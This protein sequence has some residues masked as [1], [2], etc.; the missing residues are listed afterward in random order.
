MLTDLTAG[1]A[2]SVTTTV[3]LGEESTVMVVTPASVWQLTPVTG[4]RSVLL[5]LT[6]PVPGA[7]AGPPSRAGGA[8]AGGGGRRG[9]FGGGGGGRGGL[10]CRCGRCA[11]G[12]AGLVRG[13]ASGQ[14]H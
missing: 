8:G 6:W 5:R 10:G 1:L 11:G 3:V 4:P 9:A 2:S 7:A 12:T 13:R 14:G